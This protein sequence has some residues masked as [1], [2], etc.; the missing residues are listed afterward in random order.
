MYKAFQEKLC[1]GCSHLVLKGVAC[2][3]RPGGECPYLE[4]EKQESRATNRPESA[5]FVVSALAISGEFDVV[6]SNN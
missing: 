1:L 6:R 3:W 2:D 4:G 5:Y